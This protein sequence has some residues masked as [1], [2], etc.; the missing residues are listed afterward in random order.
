MLKNYLKIALRRL[1]KHKVDSVIS[2]GGLAVGIACCLLLILSVRFEFTYD[3]FHENG[4]RIFRL[5]SHNERSERD[6]MYSTKHPYPMASVM[7]STF[8]Q[9]AHTVRM[10]GDR[11]QVKMDG[12][13]RKE[14]ILMADP[15]FFQMF[16]FPLLSGS[17]TQVLVDPNS[18]VLSKSM[19]DK[20]F[21][22]ASA[23]GKSLTLQM[24]GEKYTYRVT[25]VADEIPSNSS[26]TFDF[27]LPIETV[28]R[29]VPRKRVEHFMEGWDIGS[30][31][32]WVMLKEEATAKSVDEKL[33]EIIETYQGSWAESMTKSLQPMDE[34]YFSQRFSH[35]LAKQSDI[36]YTLLLAAI[37]L[38]ILS[39][40]G[41]NFMSL[42]LS[43]ITGREHGIG[44]RKS[45]G[46]SRRELAFQVLGEI[47]V[48][49]TLAL[50]LGIILAEWV[51]PYFRH[52]IQ[53]PVHPHLFSDPVSWLLIFAI[54]PVLTLVT[55]WYPAYV[56]AT[57]KAVGLFRSRRSAERIPAFVKGLMV[58]QFAFTIAFLSMTF[59]MRGQ[60]TYL[61]SKDL[62]FNS[63]N[64]I[65]I[66]INMN[67]DQ[68]NKA[69]QVYIK[70]VEKLPD[71]QRASLAGTNFEGVAYGSGMA[72]SW[73]TTTTING[74]DGKVRFE[75]AGDNYLEV[76]NISLLQGKRFAEMAPANLEDKII[77]N[78]KLMDVTGW[79]HPVGKN[80][81]DKS[82]RREGMLHGKTIIG[83]MGNF[84]FQPLYEEI[85]PMVLIHRSNEKY[86]NTASI[87]V[88]AEK[89][90]IQGTI[91]K[92]KQQWNDILPEQTFDYALLDELL[93]Q[94]YQDE[95]RWKSIMEAASVMAILL[96]CFGLFGLASLST[97]RRTR[98]IGIRKVLGAKISQMVWLLN[99]DFLKWVLLGIV[100]GVPL[101]WY[102]MHR[103]L[104]IF[105]YKI[106]LGPRFFIWAGLLTVGIAFVT[107][108]WKSLRAATANPADS[109][110]NE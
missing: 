104:A 90:Q 16:S 42:T 55:G 48:T 60:V 25:G 2:I 13:Y 88:K 24:E 59:I 95:E 73:R 102:V 7:D 12:K 50:L 85:K 66:P 45:A 91:E 21:G 14:R 89:G 31:T 35:T 69:A 106:E 81:V 93:K 27:V 77:V 19:A 97:Q 38:L 28:K 79:E 4:D 63:K 92:L 17:K 70:E 105:A 101:A 110:R 46:A 41:M 96:A 23:L 99:K 8:P 68:S 87:L 10:M 11:V 58:A 107:V 22:D 65:T 34:V 33:P 32:I 56:I 49:S 52:F 103:W 53:K 20:Y 75:A 54:I 83:V 26:I 40:A 30:S 108:S 47:M 43:R 78:K 5:V 74:L 109:I 29:S 61:F 86:L 15:D 37:A 18:I 71:V 98:E 82:E 94:Q 67:N 1:A 80:I 72:A 51:A 6:D 100:I 44:I 84:H 62:G 39:I 76:L 57:R 36:Q 64:V 9:I 3:D